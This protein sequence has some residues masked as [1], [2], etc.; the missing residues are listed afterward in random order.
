MPTVGFGREIVILIALLL[1]LL[2]LLLNHTF[3]Q[4]F[5]VKP[6]PIP[7]FR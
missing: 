7:D 4:L 1:L 6:S 5:A 3:Q 2:L